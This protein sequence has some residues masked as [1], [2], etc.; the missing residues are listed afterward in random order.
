MIENEM[1][2]ET[3]RDVCPAIRTYFCLSRHRPSVLPLI[4]LLFPRIPLVAVIP[5]SSAPRLSA[6]LVIRQ[7]F[8]F[9]GTFG[10]NSYNLPR[11]SAHPSRYS[12]SACLFGATAI[13]V[14]AED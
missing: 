5:R 8:A 1:N 9:N 13:K 7:N 10:L 3:Q 4:Q 2:L 12:P 14:L 11:L 6:T